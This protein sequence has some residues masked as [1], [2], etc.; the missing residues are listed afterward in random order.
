M[1]HLTR[2]GTRVEGITENEDLEQRDS[3]TFQMFEESTF[4]C[5]FLKI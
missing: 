1:G 3:G 2:A 4:Q 5:F